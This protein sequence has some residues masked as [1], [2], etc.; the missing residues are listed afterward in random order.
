MLLVHRAAV[1]NRIEEFSELGRQWT[2][3]VEPNENAFC[4]RSSDLDVRRPL[5]A[6]S[7]W[8][9]NVVC[10]QVSSQHFGHGA[11]MLELRG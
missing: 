10:R 9:V 2:A 1:Q 7:S 3:V 4:A 8:R 11:M 6:R 5:G